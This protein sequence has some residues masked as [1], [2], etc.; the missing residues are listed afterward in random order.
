MYLCDEG[1]LTQTRGHT[2]AQQMCGKPIISRTE[3]PWLKLKGI[4]A[5]FN[6]LV[7]TPVRTAV[8]ALGVFDAFLLLLF[9]VIINASVKIYLNQIHIPQVKHLWDIGKI[10][11]NVAFFKEIDR[12]KALF[13]A[14][15]NK[16]VRENKQN[17]F[18]WLGPDILHEIFSDPKLFGKNV[19]WRKI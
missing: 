9:S 7:P 10:V 13:P 18:V 11:I 17:T 19:R 4:S 1:R 15:Y 6:M 8:Q 12:D 16:M 14:S 5:V 2:L 3:S